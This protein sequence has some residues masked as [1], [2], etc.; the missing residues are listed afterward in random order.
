MRPENGSAP[1]HY[2]AYV[3][4]K[5]AL[6][7]GGG[8]LAAI[9]FFVSVSVGSVSIPIPDIIAT[10]LGWQGTGLYNTIIWNIRIPQA[11]TAVVAGAGLAIAG[12]AM[13]SVLRNPLA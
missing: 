4:R 10:L 13:Q 5:V 8:I 6:I 11:L 7:L 9:M 12:V 3:G 2:R 1:E